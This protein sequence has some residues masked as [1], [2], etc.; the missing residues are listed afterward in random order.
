MNAETRL[1][2]LED[3]GRAGAER[4]LKDH[5][6][7]LE[8]ERAGLPVPSGMWG[9]K[10]KALSDQVEA[11]KPSLTAKE[12]GKQHISDTVF[13]LRRLIHECP[14]RDE[15]QSPSPCRGSRKARPGGQ[16]P[17]GIDR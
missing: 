13:R 16:T 4:R 12:R 15:H 7:R 9:D 10:E 6:L 5:I 14:R 1:N 2:C 8:H 11:Y 3:Q 17:P